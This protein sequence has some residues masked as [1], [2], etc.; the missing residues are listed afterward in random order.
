MNILAI[1]PARSGSKGIV[2]KNI[3]LLR[4]HPLIE[5]SIEAARR[6]ASIDRV[7]V[8]TDSAKIATMAASLGAEAPF[9]RPPELAQDDTPGIDPI[10]HAVEWLRDQER[11][12]PDLVCCLQPTSP[13]RTAADIDAALAVAAAKR[14]DA[15]VSVTAALQHPR[16]MK[17]VDADGRVSDFLPGAT[18][19][20][21]RQDLPP[22]FALNGA[23]YLG[24][25]DVLLS[26]RTWYTERTYAYIMPA[27]R[28]LDIDTAWDLALAEWALSRK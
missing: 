27:E 19:V 5:Y 10:L 22:V 18:P 9:L 8:S 17:C 12:Q 25:T 16:W 20:A 24:R 1:I 2:D 7:I 13:L 21:R 4:G 15:V 23:I 28:S 6:A 11:Y 3:Q 14:A 26:R